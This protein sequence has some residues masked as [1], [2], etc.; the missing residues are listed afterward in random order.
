MLETDAR[1]GEMKSHRYGIRFSVRPI[2]APKL[3]VAN[4]QNP[5]YG[6]SGG[7]ATD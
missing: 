2:V 3:F 1:F 7:V 6:D 4:T 5:V